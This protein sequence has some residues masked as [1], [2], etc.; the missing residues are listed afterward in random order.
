MIPFI[1]ASIGAA[2]ADEPPGPPPALDDSS[3]LDSIASIEVERLRF[4]KRVLG[5]DLTVY[6]LPRPSWRTVSV[7]TVIDGGR[8]AEPDAGLTRVLVDSWLASSPTGRGAVSDLYDRLGS[9]A[10]IRVR[11]ESTVFWVHGPA[12]ALGPLLALERQRFANPLVRVREAAAPSRTTVRDGGT[13]RYLEVVFSS[14]Y[15]ESHPYHDLWKPRERRP[16]ALTTAAA[17]A[18]ATWTPSRATLVVAGPVEPQEVWCGLDPAACQEEVT[19]S[20]AEATLALP[21]PEPVVWS[22][23]IPRHTDIGPV[24]IG[25]SSTSV[26][27]D[28]LLLTWSIPGVADGGQQIGRWARLEVEQRLAS[29][30]GVPGAARCRLFE[31]QAASTLV[32]R[33][34]APADSDLSRMRRRWDRRLDDDAAV[35]VDGWRRQRL[36]ELLGA[37]DDA[38]HVPVVAE[39]VHHTG[40]LEP[41]GGAAQGL[42][43]DVEGAR[44]YVQVVL[45][46]ERMVVVRLVP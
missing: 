39:H 17:H 7:A 3:S 44:D 8:M 40:E 37:T 31:G 16:V 43:F 29:T 20:E 13:A 22:A 18:Q 46:S 6:V 30:R 25:S 34:T 28:T 12:D 35:P 5:D 15:P 45:D 14:L 32:C 42:A 27:Q 38:T 1:F 11:P 41:Y 23:P 33:I 4:A 36:L 9:R 21:D 19:L 10:E 2:V 24:T 26:P